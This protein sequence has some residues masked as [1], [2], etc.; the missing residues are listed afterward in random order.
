VSVRS[1]VDF[2]VQLLTVE[3]ESSPLR[4][5]PLI[6]TMLER[7]VIPCRNDRKISQRLS[8]STTPK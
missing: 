5:P 1:L 6:V 4:G 3:N 8:F 2:D 7:E